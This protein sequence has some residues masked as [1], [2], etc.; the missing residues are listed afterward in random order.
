MVFIIPS[1]IFFH[2]YNLRLL[3]DPEHK[4][5]KLQVWKEFLIYIQVSSVTSTK[6][7]YYEIN[8]DLNEKTPFMISES[9]GLFYK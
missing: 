9:V 6:L 2:L 7:I 8:L 1:I 4:S 5:R 3:P